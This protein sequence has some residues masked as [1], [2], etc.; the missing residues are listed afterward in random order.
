MIVHGLGQRLDRKGHAP[1]DQLVEHDAQRIDVRAPVDL[2]SHAL[3]GRHVSR[4]SHGHA[5]LG[6]HAPFGKLRQ[7]KVGQDGLDRQFARFLQRGLDRAQDHVRG[8]D[9]AMQDPALVRTVQGEGD[10]A[11]NAQAFLEGHDLALLRQPLEPLVERLSLDQV[12][13]DVKHPQILPAGIDLDDAGMVEAGDGACLLAK[14]RT[15]GRVVSKVRVHDLDRNI[16]VQR[17]IVSLVHRS[18]AAPRQASVNAICLV[19]RLS[20]KY[21]HS[22][23]PR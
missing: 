17:C 19:E 15:E 21:V 18:H 20:D 14:A 6:V 8:L 12:H 7:A 2:L 22:H 10:G 23:F 4:R 1:G 16:A 13:R 5:G 3:L 9:V 11:D